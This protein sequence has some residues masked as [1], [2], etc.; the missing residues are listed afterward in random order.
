MGNPGASP[1]RTASWWRRNAS[2]RSLN[3]RSISTHGVKDERAVQYYMRHPHAGD[4]PICV[5][6][7]GGLFGGY[8]AREGAHRIEAARRTGRRVRCLVVDLDKE[9]GG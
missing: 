5:V 1:G 2:S 6:R 8:W 4:T 7:T 9:R 3:P